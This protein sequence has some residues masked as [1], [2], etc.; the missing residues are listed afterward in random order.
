MSKGYTS[1][2]ARTAPAEPAIA[3]PHG[4]K[5]STFDCPAIVYAPEYLLE[6]PECD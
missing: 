3:L 2:F 5:A 4:G 1:A 6:T